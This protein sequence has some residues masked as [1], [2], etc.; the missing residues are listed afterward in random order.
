MTLATATRADNNDAYQALN[1][2]RNATA[3]QWMTWA[4]LGATIDHGRAFQSLVDDN[5]ILG[6]AGLGLQFT[7]VENTLAAF[8]S[9]AADA[10]ITTFIAP[11][12]LLSLCHVGLILIISS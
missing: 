5:P 8:S 11:L 2:Y 12:L 7:E 4:G 9:S 6:T 10:V 1:A 3:T